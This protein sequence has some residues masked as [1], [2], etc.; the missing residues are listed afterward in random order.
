MLNGCEFHGETHEGVMARWN[1]P[2]IEKQHEPPVTLCACCDGPAVAEMHPAQDEAGNDLPGGVSAPV[3]CSRCRQVT[4]EQWE[5]IMA[6]LNAEP[7][8]ALA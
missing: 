3:L 5:A 2:R 7:V 1:D 6:R 8:E 4:P